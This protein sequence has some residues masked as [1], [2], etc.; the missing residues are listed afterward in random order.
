MGEG[1]AVQLTANVKQ[2]ARSP[3]ST[4]KFMGRTVRDNKEAMPSAAKF[5]D[6][7]YLQ[8]QTIQEELLKVEKIVAPTRELTSEQ[9]AAMNDF[10]AKST[11]YQK[12]GYDIEIDGKKIKADPLMKRS[13]DKLAPAA[14]SVAKDIFSYNIET[15]AKMKEEAEARGVKDVFK[16]SK[17]DGPYAKLSRFGG[18]VTVLRSAPLMRLQAEVQANPKN[19]KMA[20]RLDEMMTKPEDYVVKFFDTMG[21]AERYAAEEGPKYKSAVA[22]EKEVGE[23]EN[24]VTN[25]EAF[26]SVMA[27]VGA[28][29][30]SGLDDVTKGSVRK[31]VEKLFYETL[32]EQ[33]ARLSGIKRLNRAGFDKDM[34]R[35]F[36]SHAQSQS[37]LLAQV[38]HGA[39]VNQALRDMKQE[40]RKNRAELQQIANV[41]SLKYQNLL[42]KDDRMFAA[43]Q[44]TITSFNSMT[45]LTTN[46]AYHVANATQTAISQAKLAGDFNSYS[47]AGGAIAKGY[48]SAFKIVDS[49]L[50]K[51]LGTVTTVGMIDM[52]NTV[53]LDI[54]KAAPEHRGVL[55]KMQGRQMLDMGIE[56]DLNMEVMFNTGYNALNTASKAFRD[57]SHRLYQSSRYVEAHNRVAVAIAAYDMAVKNPAV[58]RRKKMTPEEYAMSIVEDTQGNY[59]NIDAPLIIDSVG[60]V[61]SQFRKFQ[62]VMGW[63]WGSTFRD[64][65]I[66]K[67]KEEKAAARRTLA[68]L[69]ANV[70]ALA[71]VRG[72]P[73]V[74]FIGTVALM[75]FSRGEEDQ[76]DP[77]DVDRW[78]KENFENDLAAEV[79]TRGLPALLGIDLSAKVQQRDIFMP[80][81]IEYIDTSPDAK[82]GMNVAYNLLLGP[83]AGTIG[84][85]DQALKQYARG[86]ISRAVEYLLPKGQR[87][88]LESLRIAQEGYSFSNGDV[89]LNPTQIGM[90]ELFRNA[91]GLTPMQL[92]N[93][94]W[95]YGQQLEITKHFT[96]E[97]SR[98]KRDYVRAKKADDG[99]AMDALRGEW[100]DLQR[101][102]DRMREFFNDDPNSIPRTD[103]GELMLSDMKKRNRERKKQRQ[104][105]VDE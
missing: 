25:P 22:S 78:I 85:F 74:G 83:T 94:K 2:V 60:K 6:T 30:K 54:E 26:A 43:A 42:T 56:Q 47:G 12:W 103:M 24:R 52:G 55:K 95:T 91:L 3:L 58:M 17:L 14:Q 57:M 40:A 27:A 10:V 21:E 29:D 48:K 71:G 8:E 77:K 59:S 82:P 87:S 90:G 37:R 33:S 35:S 92:S 101:Q 18:Y 105:G 64:A 51:Q 96:D 84:N 100:R 61:T 49:S 102:K 62:L 99:K 46:V 66:G 93:V 39:E 50:L 97:Q 5:L 88:A 11:L 38:R 76:D 86:D 75:A 1:A 63:L 72:V 89:I 19:T 34:V 44:D 104:L 7:L 65:M 16:S 31:I 23:L 98:M 36:V 41:L 80:L 13:F 15:R 4:L 53:A 67:S 45:M 70:A 81:N 32:D 69:G 20:K 73:F 68:Y 28:D 9:L 79:L